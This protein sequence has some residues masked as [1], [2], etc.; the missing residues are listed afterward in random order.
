LKTEAF[1]KVNS[2][3]IEQLDLLLRISLALRVGNEQDVGLSDANPLLPF[4]AGVAEGI[5][6]LRS[7]NL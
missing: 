7:R 2:L 1:A 5:K 6:F 4:A 3:L